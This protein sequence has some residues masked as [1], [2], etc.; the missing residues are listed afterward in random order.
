MSFTVTVNEHCAP[1]AVQVTVVVPRGKNDP[2]AG[3]QV[4]VPPQGVVTEGLTTAPHW[5]G[6]LGTVMLSG[7]IIVHGS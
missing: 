2:A 3:E 6:S 7:Q 1:S 5:P 4:I